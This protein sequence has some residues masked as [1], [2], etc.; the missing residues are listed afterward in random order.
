MGTADGPARDGS[1]RS[2][3]SDLVQQSVVDSF[4]RGNGGRAVLSPHPA[5]SGVGTRQVA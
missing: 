4:R 3:V 1:D 2:S 5:H